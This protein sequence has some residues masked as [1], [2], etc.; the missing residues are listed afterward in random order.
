MY[1][2]R[3]R[4]ISESCEF[5]NDEDMWA[6]FITHNIKIEFWRINRCSTNSSCLYVNYKS[7]TWIWYRL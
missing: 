5:D 4:K 6:K 3:V 7:Q 2:Q 1:Y